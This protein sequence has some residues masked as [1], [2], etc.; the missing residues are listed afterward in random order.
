[1][2]EALEHSIH[3]LDHERRIRALEEEMFAG[4]A[5]ENQDISAD[6]GESIDERS[7]NGEKERETTMKN[8]IEREI[9][10]RSEKR[11]TKYTNEKAR[12][13]TNR[14]QKEREYLSEIDDEI[15]ENQSFIQRFNQ[16]SHRENNVEERLNKLEG[17]L[18]LKKREIMREIA[19]SMTVREIHLQQQERYQ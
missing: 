5:R 19:T 15:E 3:A 18:S 16:D 8:Q 6:D 12:E 2:D 1:M 13:T 4:D 11:E 10:E 9:S 14:N 7:E 17:S